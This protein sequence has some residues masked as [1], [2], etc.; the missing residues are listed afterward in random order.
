[1]PSTNLTNPRSDRG[2]VPDGGSVPLNIVR[3]VLR[4]SGVQGSGK[5]YL[6]YLVFTFKLVAVKSIDWSGS[7]GD[8]PVEQVVFEYGSLVVTYM[9]QN[10]DGSLGPP[11]STGWNRVSNVPELP[12]P[13]PPF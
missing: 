10:P 13:L 6:P 5:P 1:M 7:G 4:R 8:R 11:T 9:K 12:S 3:L 2:H